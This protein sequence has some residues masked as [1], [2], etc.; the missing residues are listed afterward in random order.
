MHQVV[1]NEWERGE[2]VEFIIFHG[3][4][5]GLRYLSTILLKNSHIFKIIELDFFKTETNY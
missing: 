3:Y 5:D 1:D 4:G 2:G